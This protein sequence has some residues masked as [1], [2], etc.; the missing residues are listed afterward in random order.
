[1]IDFIYLFSP[2]ATKCGRDLNERKDK[3][4]MKCGY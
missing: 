4:M 2:Q 3:R 1:M